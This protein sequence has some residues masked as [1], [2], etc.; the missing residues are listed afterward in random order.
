[1]M[2]KPESFNRIYLQ[3][4]R[5]MTP[6]QNDVVDLMVTSPPYNVTK[7]YDDNLSERICANVGG[8]VEG[9]VACF[10]ARGIGGN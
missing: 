6:L 9:S 5:K 3:D 10:K 7:Q 4:S 1:M 2:T 8:C